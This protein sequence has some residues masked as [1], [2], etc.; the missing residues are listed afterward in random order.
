[1]TR[2]SSII[3]AAFSLSLAACSA[4]PEP[5]EN[6]LETEYGTGAMLSV[7][8]YGDTDV[9]G[10]HFEITRVSC[11][12]GD[13]I[14]PETIEANVDLLDGIVPGMVTLVEQTLDP[15][16][17]HLGSDL[18]LTL[19]PGCYDIIAAPASDID[20]D[21][22][23]PSEDCSTA[24]AEGI[25][26]DE[27]LTTETTLISQCVGDGVGALDTLV[28]LN[29]PPTLAVAIDEKF[30]YECEPVEICVT[31]YDVDDDPLELV[32]VNLSDEEEFSI[33][34]GDPTIV[35][36]DDGH[37]VWEQCAQVVTRWTTT[38]DFQAQV[39]DLGREGGQE[40]RMEAITGELSRAELTFPIHTNWVEE[41]MCMNEE[42]EAELAEG[43]SI[44]RAEGCGYT[45]A[46]RF[47]CSG[48]YDH[49]VD[50]EIQAFL[51]D[52]GELIEDRLY[53]DCPTD[54][55]PQAEK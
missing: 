25:Q 35:D 26:V 10:F 5:G 23:S 19:E 45:D 16:S 28:T 17:N 9:V 50:P 49:M 13:A 15:D 44:E 34:Y 11:D 48:A 47:Y 52:D 40:V 24:T 38:Y 21:Q 41:P 53:P 55:E 3:A 39:F 6:Q 2:I 18:F 36:Y 43:V 51:C 54:D 30:N 31:A 7:D 22:W 20:G 12:A 4:S 33:T 46:E 42:G 32:L 1:M 8:Y 14:T 27:G 37:R 29:H